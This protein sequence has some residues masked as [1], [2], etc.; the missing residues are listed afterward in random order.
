MIDGNLERLIPDIEVF[1]GQS[2]CSQIAPA[3]S[4]STQCVSCIPTAAAIGRV[5]SDSCALVH[6][7]ISSN[8]CLP[9]SEAANYMMAYGGH[10][11]PTVAEMVGVDSIAT[12]SGQDLFEEAIE[13]CPGS[14]DWDDILH[15]GGED[16]PDSDSPARGSEGSDPDVGHNDN[17]NEGEYR[18]WEHGCNGRRFSTRSNLQ[19]HL[20][21]KSRQRP[22]WKCPDCDAVFSRTTA[23]NQH[24][25]NKSCNRIRRYSNGR[26]RPMPRVID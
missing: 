8:R 14:E 12:S 18:C 5:S 11:A 13:W 24:V 26:K 17:A 25:Y 16:A 4:A 7:Q 3:L 19:R 23:R 10:A 22:K 1:H 6:P 21:E 9:V 2:S 20:T 15:S